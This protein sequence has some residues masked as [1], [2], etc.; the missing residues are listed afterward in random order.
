MASRK[1]VGNG[2]EKIIVIPATVAEDTMHQALIQC[3]ND[4]GS[5]RKIHIRNG[6]W[7]QVCTTKTIRDIVPLRTP[8]PTSVNFL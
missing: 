8:G 1:P 5:C 3:L 7:Q 4:A 6:E 2:R